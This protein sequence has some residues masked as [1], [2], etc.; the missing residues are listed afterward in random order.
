L[1]LAR[2]KARLIRF[3]LIL[4]LAQNSGARLILLCGYPDSMNIAI[5]PPAQ[6]IRTKFQTRP[7]PYNGPGQ[8]RVGSAPGFGDVYP[9]LWSMVDNTR[10]QRN[11]SSRW[12]T[13]SP[14]PNLRSPALSVKFITLPIAA[15]WIH[16]GDRALGR[17]DDRRTSQSVWWALASSIGYNPSAGRSPIRSVSAKALTDL[18][19]WVFVVMKCECEGRFGVG[20]RLG[21]NPLI[22]DRSRIGVWITQ[23]RS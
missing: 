8:G 3:I 5:G 16:L 21:K 20:I 10:G 23:D 13:S 19:F 7:W 22:Q 12:L 1:I 9:N 2:F 17:E 18:S 11:A 14:A 6:G 4:I 15:D